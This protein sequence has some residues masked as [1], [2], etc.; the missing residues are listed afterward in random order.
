[1]E[2]ITNKPFVLLRYVNVRSFFYFG[3]F[4][5]MGITNKDVLV[6]RYENDMTEKML[7]L[8]KLKK[9]EIRNKKL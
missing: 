8:K 9:Y 5:D 4:N 6:V 7:I 2:V 3:N 1:V